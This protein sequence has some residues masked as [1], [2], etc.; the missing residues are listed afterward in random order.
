MRPAAALHF[1]D[2]EG[3]GDEAYVFV[4][5]MPGAIGLSI[6]T[7]TGPE[8]EVYLSPADCEDLRAALQ[9]AV[10]IARTSR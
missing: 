2:R 5:A 10:A 9:Q 8:C 6:S 7:K 4:R 1:K 3:S